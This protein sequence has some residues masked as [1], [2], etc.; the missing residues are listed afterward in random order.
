MSI[1]LFDYDSNQVRV[2]EQDGEPWFVA[3]DVCRVLEIA[4]SRDA[5]N[6]LDG[7]DVGTA[8]VRSGGQRRTMTTVNES[9]LW[10]LVLDSRKPEAKKFR[11]W[12]TSAVLPSLRKTGKYDTSES[13]KPVSQ[14]D[15]LATAVA[16]LQ[17]VEKLALVASQTAAEVKQEVS[18]VSG[19]VDV[20][21]GTAGWLA[22]GGYLR[23]S[24]HQLSDQNA[25]KLGR[26]ARKIGEYRGLE[27]GS[28]P[29]PRF[30]YV[31]TWPEEVWEDAYLSLGCFLASRHAA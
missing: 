28:T 27:A 13:Q 11:R 8:D 4:N 9:G 29:H 20:L 10:D 22:A 31:N 30:I 14:L 15:V 3:S 19:R 18:T 21:E 5:V 23:K 1:M 25:N 2:L 6:R 24:G 16:E 26:I 7:A 17:R 12:V